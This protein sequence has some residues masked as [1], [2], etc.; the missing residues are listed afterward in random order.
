MPE[1]IR[2]GDLVSINFDG[3]VQKATTSQDTIGVAVEPE[4]RGTVVVR[5]SGTGSFPLYTLFKTCSCGETVHVGMKE[6][7]KP[8][9]NRYQI[10]KESC[11]K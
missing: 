9:K 3:S 2:V 11:S 5:T 4:R 1:M 7:K 6:D 8:C 10:L